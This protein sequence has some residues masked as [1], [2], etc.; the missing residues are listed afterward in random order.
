[1]KINVVDVASSSVLTALSC[2]EITEEPSKPFYSIDE[3]SLIIPSKRALLP[4]G[5]TV[6]GALTSGKRRVGVSDREMMTGL[7]KTKKQAAT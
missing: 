2:W 7:F 5:F 4:H 1:M 3:S 6:E